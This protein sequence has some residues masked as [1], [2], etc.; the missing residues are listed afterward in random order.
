[1][2]D[3]LDAIENFWHQNQESILG[4]RMRG[5]VYASASAELI[6]GAA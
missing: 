4:E 3:I 5:N 6:K 1:V 2:T